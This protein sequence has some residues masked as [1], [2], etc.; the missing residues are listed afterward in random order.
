MTDRN[1]LGEA[2]ELKDER[3]SEAYQAMLETVSAEMWE[4]WRVCGSMAGAE[5]SGLQIHNEAMR[6]LK[7]NQKGEN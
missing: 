7:R 4:A 3:D 6:R 1:Q 2:R 5:P